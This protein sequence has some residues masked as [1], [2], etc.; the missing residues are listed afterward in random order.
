MPKHVAVR[1]GCNILYINIGI[2]WANDTE[3][4]A[5]YK[6]FNLQTSQV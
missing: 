3:V 4:G 1:I 5:G 6:N 2:T